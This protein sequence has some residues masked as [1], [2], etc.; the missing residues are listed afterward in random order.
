MLRIRRVLITVTVNESCVSRIALVVT[1]I[2][3]F[4]VMLTVARKGLKG[5]DSGP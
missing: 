2:K 5:M 3:M 1:L 4:T